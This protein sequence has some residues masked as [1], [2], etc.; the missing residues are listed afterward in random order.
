MFSTP[1]RQAVIYSDFH[2]RVRVLPLGKTEPRDLGWS[3][4]ACAFEWR[5]A[6]P[7]A[8]HLGLYRAFA[9]LVEH[10]GIPASEVHRAFCAI[11]EYRAGLS[12]CHPHAMSEAERRKLRVMLDLP[13]AS[14]PLSAF[15]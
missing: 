9:E 8:L 6:D 1:L 3:M 15:T 7:D 5:E 13:R 10:A 4:G 2:S 11:P 14:S 12:P